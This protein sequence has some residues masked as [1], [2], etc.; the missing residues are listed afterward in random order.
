[1][2]VVLSSHNGH[3]LLYT[4]LD[5][6]FLMHVHVYGVLLRDPPSN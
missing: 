5:P 1:M 4:D 6:T 2:Y 3:N